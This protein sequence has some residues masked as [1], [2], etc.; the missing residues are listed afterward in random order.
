MVRRDVVVDRGLVGPD[1]VRASVRGPIRAPVR[2][3][4]TPRVRRPRRPPARR[5]GRRNR[6]L[7]HAVG[8]RL[9]PRDVREAR[10]GAI[11]ASRRDRARS[12]PR[13]RA[14]AC[15]YPR[16]PSRWRSPSTRERV[17]RRRGVPVVD[18]PRPRPRAPCCASSAGSCRGALWIVELDPA[19]SRDR[20]AAHA[21][22]LSSRVLRR[23]F[24]PIVVGMAP[25]A[26]EI[27]ASAIA[28]GW[29]VTRSARRSDPARL[30]RGARLM[31]MAG[32]ARWARLAAELHREL[33]EVADL[34]S[35]RS[36]LVVARLRRRL[37]VGARRCVRDLRCR[38]GVRYVHRAS[39][40]RAERSDRRCD[41]ARP[42]RPRRDPRAR[43]R[44]SR[45]TARGHDP[46][47]RD[48]RVRRAEP[49]RAR[50]VRD[51]RSLLVR[52]ARRRSH[53]RP[54][55]RRGA[56]EPARADEDLEAARRRRRRSSASR[57]AKNRSP[58]RATAIAA[59]GA[60]R[61]N[62][63]R[64]L[65]RSESRRRHGDRVDLPHGRRRLRSCAPGCPDP[66]A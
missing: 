66:E 60:T 36:A 65:V 55:S 44:A 40:A 26:E 2:R 20:I 43:R 56:R 64:A 59:P 33:R 37:A 19:A 52:A 12:E 39:R 51:R 18:P 11:S 7:A 58:P 61:R 62:L 35:D 25:P 42:R 16:G 27:E 23:A 29:R 31:V 32:T 8:A 30:H 13:L 53:A 10:R 49:A 17:D 15:L 24:G 1:A 63:G 9:R 50:R 3:G 57:S 5:L 22:R 46:P 21:D 47:P 14:P 38:A 28:A 4:R 48:R 34:A 41:R 45:S 6:A 54:G